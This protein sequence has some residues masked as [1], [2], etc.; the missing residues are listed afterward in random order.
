AAAIGPDRLDERLAVPPTRDELARLAATLNDML[1]RIQR[2][3]EEQ[4]RLVADASHELRTP[5]AAMRS[6]LDVSLLA[7]D[8]SPAARAVLLS[9]REEVDRMS[10]TVD[11]LLTLAAGDEG[12]L[13]LLAGPLDL[14]DVAGDAAAALAALA[15][16]RGVRVEV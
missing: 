1:G 7:D 8:L 15:E 16:A 13:D 14:A 11:D 2:G 9:T 4:R 6:E 12:R 3:A 5:L 10:R